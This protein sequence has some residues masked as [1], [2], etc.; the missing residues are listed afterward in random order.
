M[1]EGLNDKEIEISVVHSLEHTDGAYLNEAYENDD[2]DDLWDS[3]IG[4][5]ASKLLPLQWNTVNS[6]PTPEI[7]EFRIEKINY[8][9]YCD[10]IRL[11]IEA[12]LNLIDLKDMSKYSDVLEFLI[13]TFS[14]QKINII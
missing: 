9:H 2:N 5:S 13:L 7:L 12:D 10:F 11:W 6:Y 8:I 4:K 14:N 1:H 3:D